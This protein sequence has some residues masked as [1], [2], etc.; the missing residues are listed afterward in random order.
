MQLTLDIDEYVVFDFETTGLSP[1]SGDEVIEVGAMKIFGNELDEV[2]VFHSL[3]NPKRK[4]P[5]DST[6]VHGI[7]DEMVASAPTVEEV[8]PK[9]LEFIENA[10]LIAQNAK[11]DMTFLS[12]YLVANNI[13]KEVEVFDTINLSRRAFPEE[14]RHNLD[15][16]CSRLGFTYEEKDRHRSLTDVKL[17]AMAFL[18]LRERLGEES[19]KPEKWSI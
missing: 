19:P 12:K 5:E 1:W 16:I 2:N 11:F 3:I 10:R 14:K 8:L 4:I 7:T 9:F 13:R 15:K 18:K 17:T 6:Q